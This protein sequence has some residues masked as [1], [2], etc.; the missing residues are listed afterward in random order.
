MKKQ[1]LGIGIVLLL[2]LC[3]GT[4][5]KPAVTSTFA[6]DSQVMAEVPEGQLEMYFA[7]EGLDYFAYMDLES[8]D[9]SLKPVIL[10]ARRRIIFSSSWVADEID[11]WVTNPDG[12][13]EEVVPH[14][15][16][17]FP[18][19]WEL[20]AVPPEELGVDLDYY[21]ISDS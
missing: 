5:D 12:T 20:P 13:V 14:F 18:S 1:I 17:I 16:E 21:G 7:A 4:E 10:E 3:T 8:A 15:S 9:A 2:L 6:E 19:D 11:G